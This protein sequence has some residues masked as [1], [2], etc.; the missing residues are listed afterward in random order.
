MCPP[1]DDSTRQSADPQPT[2]A[3]SKSEKGANPRNFGAL[4]FKSARPFVGRV[5]DFAGRLNSEYRQS[6]VRKESDLFEY[7]SLIPVDMLVRELAFSK[8]DDGNERYLYASIRGR[9]ARQHPGHL[10]RVCEREDHLVNKLVLAYGARYGRER[11]VRRHLR[12]K[13]SRIEFAQRGF[14][15]PAGHNGYV[16]DIS[17][18]DHGGERGFRIPCHEFMVR[19]FLP[20]MR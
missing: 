19:V 14:P 4:R 1:A 16:I 7:G 11:S 13:A 6:R 2:K 8:L 17:V 20:K 3:R 5:D 18:L 10:L 12:D 15:E 9:D